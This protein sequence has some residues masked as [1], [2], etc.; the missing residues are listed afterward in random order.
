MELLTFDSPIYQL[1]AL[2]AIL[3]FCS[4]SWEQLMNVIIRIAHIKYSSKEPK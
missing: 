2:L 3:L 1:S 4:L